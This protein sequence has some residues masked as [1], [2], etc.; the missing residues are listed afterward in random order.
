MDE[1]G[2][3][4]RMLPDK[5]LTTSDKV[6]GA[7]KNKDRITVSLCS[8][9]DGSEKLKPLVIGKSL[10]PRCFKNF[11]H[12]LYVDYKANKK[13][14]MTSVVFA[15]WLKVF[16]ARMRRKKQKVLLLLDNAPSHIIPT[17]LPHVKIH[18]LPPNTT[19][20]LRPLDAGIIQSFKSHYRRF[21][22]QHIINCIDSDQPPAVSLSDAIRYV[23][24]SWDKVTATTILHCW[25]HT[26][27]ISSESP[28]TDPASTNS[29]EAGSSLITPLLRVVIEKTSDSTRCLHVN[30]RIHERR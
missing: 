20:H 13:S 3:F 8:N 27:I 21:H 12:N 1:T 25:Q 4:F 30:H 29:S 6:T 14:W 28:A 7:K 2:L 10:N 22:L 18:F 17:G 5:S 15:E 9:A 24:R 26:G 19:S 16:N 11:N 23:K